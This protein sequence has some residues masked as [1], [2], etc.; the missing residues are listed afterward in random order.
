MLVVSIALSYL[1]LAFPI[2]ILIC[3]AVAIIFSVVAS[4]VTHRWAFWIMVWAITI[5][6]IVSIAQTFHNRDQQ[7][8]LMQR[9]EAAEQQLTE[10]RKLHKEV[11]AELAQ[12]RMMSESQEKII[13][14]FRQEFHSESHAAQ[15]AT[16]LKAELERKELQN[17]ALRLKNSYQTEL[18]HLEAGLI[19]K[20]QYDKCVNEWAA[21]EDSGP[22]F[23]N[24]NNLIPPTPIY[25]PEPEFTEAARA[26][27]RNGFRGTVALA[28]IVMP[29]GMVCNL[30]VK[31]SLNYGL[32]EEA[33]RAAYTWR[34]KP[35]KQ[36]GL[37]VP[38]HMTFEVEFNLW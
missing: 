27:Y 12:T 37:V 20:E 5:Q 2:A 36:G 31:K 18:R 14:L 10:E 29:S 30:E 13:E 15:D 9:L 4:H 34:F 7:T 8:E 24:A 25:T 16:L 33:I 3:G 21:L 35:A 19:S 6:L 17:Q 23:S 26:A 32:D 1:P 11:K 22:S 28:A 38:V